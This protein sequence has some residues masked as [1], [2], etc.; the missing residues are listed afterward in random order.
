VAMLV[1]DVAMGCKMGL[2]RKMR[3]DARTCL[4]SV[5]REPWFAMHDLGNLK[6]R[7]GD[8]WGHATGCWLDGAY[9]EEHVVF[10]RRGH[11]IMTQLYRDAVPRATH[12]PQKGRCEMHGGTCG[13]TALRNTFT[14]HDAPTQNN[15]SKSPSAQY[16]LGF[17]HFLSTSY[18]TM[19]AL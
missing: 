7:C 1:C 3:C 15:A 13:M 19:A 16:C 17:F 12:V 5:E 6:H 2:W 9:W 14:R 18:Y 11:D 8:N 4:C 10:D